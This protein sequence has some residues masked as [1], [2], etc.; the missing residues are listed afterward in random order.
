MK[1]V[2]LAHMLFVKTIFAYLGL[3]YITNIGNKGHVK[4]NTR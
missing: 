3:K 1:V 4:W 2:C